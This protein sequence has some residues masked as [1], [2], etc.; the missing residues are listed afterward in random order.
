MPTLRLDNFHPL[1]YL[2]KARS[3]PIAKT[4]MAALNMPYPADPFV[5]PEFV[6]LT[7]GE[8]AII[9][10]TLYAA[11]GSQDSLNFLLDRAIGK[12]QQTN[13]NLNATMTYQDFLDKTAAELEK[14]NVI[15]VTH[16][17]SD[18]IT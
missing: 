11:N 2:S 15:N 12:A 3:L 9:R 16:R 7:C 4:I 6:G 17:E 14:E 1:E 13:L 18:E 10:Q 5:E 8:V